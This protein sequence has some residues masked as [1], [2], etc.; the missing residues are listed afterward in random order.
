MRAL[1]R[2]CCINRTVRNFKANQ[3]NKTQK[4]VLNVKYKNKRGL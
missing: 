4:G 2:P 3:S 1:R